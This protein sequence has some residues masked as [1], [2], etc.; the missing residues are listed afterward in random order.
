MDCFFAGRCLLLKA[1]PP[2]SSRRPSFELE[3]TNHTRPGFS[4]ARYWRLPPLPRSLGLKVVLGLE[5]I[6]EVSYW[7]MVYRFLERSIQ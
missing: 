2:I 3:L 1:L 5:L 7:E 4:V 6:Q